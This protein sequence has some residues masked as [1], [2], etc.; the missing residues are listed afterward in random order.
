LGTW[1]AYLFESGQICYRIFRWIKNPPQVTRG[2]FREDGR[3]GRSSFGST[4][5]CCQS[6][7]LA[8]AA[9]IGCRTFPGHLPSISSCF[10]LLSSLPETEPSDVSG[11]RRTGVWSKLGRWADDEPP[12]I[13][14]DAV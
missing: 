1:P 12:R 4:S 14:T 2:S 6:D 11:R 8:V 10:P 13:S 9:S 7:H 5:R 3:F